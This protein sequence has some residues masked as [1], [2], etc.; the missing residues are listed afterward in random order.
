MRRRPRRA[1][2]STGCA[3][4]RRCMRVG[5]RRTS[6]YCTNIHAGRDRGPRSARTSSARAR[7]EGA[8][9]R[10]TRRSASAC[11]CR[12]APRASSRA[13]TSA[14]CATSSTRNGLYVF[15]INGFPYG[16]FHGARV[17]EDGLP[18][19]WLERRA[20]RVH[21]PAR[22]AARRAAARRRRRHDQHGA[23]LLP[24]AR[25]RRRAASPSACARTRVTWALRDAPA[26]VR[27]R[28]SPSR[29][30]ARDD[31]RGR[32][33]LRR[34]HRRLA[35]HVGAVPRR[36]P[37]RR[38]VRGRPTRRA[39]AARRPDREDPGERGPA[40]RAR[41][42]PRRAPRSRRF[43]E[44][45]Y[46]HQVVARRGDARSRATSICPR[47]SPTRRR[48]RRVAHPLPRP[49]LPRGARP[50]REHAAVPRGAA[51][52]HQ[53]RRQSRRTSRS[54]PTPGTCCPPSSAPSPIE[55]AIA[56]ELA[57]G[58]MERL[59]DEAARTALPARPRAR[60]CRRY[61]PTC[62]PRSRSP[63]RAPSSGD[64]RRSPASR[65]RCSTSAACSSTT[66][67]IATSTAR[68]GPS[69]RSRRARSRAAIVFDVGFGLLARRHRAG[70]RRRDRRRRR[71]EAACSRR[72]RSRR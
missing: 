5:E 23:R 25:R 68:S 30:P 60:T 45:V 55:D 12:R 59:R 49:D 50:V 70:R 37:R 3:P 17:K 4:A 71:L 40:R 46:L 54:R 28:S 32:R 31:R 63:A 42:T 61:G 44:G 51:R 13:A 48:G 6:R 11:G 7:G 39:L 56:R 2:R 43:A 65:C 62:S 52:A 8:R 36:L 58:R 1:A 64:D 69:G 21:G 67:S 20:P 26:T 24:R 10:P 41:S 47:R 9:L 29:L 34:T 72:S 22:R 15:T 27:S 18:P 14:S 16:A 66:R 38:R 53:A 19:D 35:A 57:L 33:V